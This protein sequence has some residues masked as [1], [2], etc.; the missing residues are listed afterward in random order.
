MNFRKSKMPTDYQLLKKIYELYIRRYSEFDN[1]NKNRQTQNYVP[2]DIKL[3]AEEFGDV[4]PNIIFGRLYY[5]L[6]EKYG[7]KRDDE[8]IVKFFAFEVGDD[9][10]CIHFPLLS[11][12]VAGLR[13]EKN[14]EV[15]TRRM[16]LW[17]L[18]LSFVSIFESF[19]PGIKGLFN[20]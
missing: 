4:E 2:I 15:F 17:A 5:H 1:K 6:E 19:L 11:S 3:I 10:H 12:V 18:L 20:Y 8:T 16:A 7:F 9:K 14:N 13:E